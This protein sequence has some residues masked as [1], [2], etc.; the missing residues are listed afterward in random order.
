MVVVK[1]KIRN[2]IVDGAQ[3]VFS[4]HGYRR[5]TMD[6]IAQVL[7]MGKS[8]IYYYFNS[9]EDIFRA[10]VEKEG[11]VLKKEINRV[12]DA[13]SSPLGKLKT[14]IR[15]RLHRLPD[16]KNL[17][18]A[19][20]KEDLPEMDFVINLRKRFNRE[21]KELV[22]RIFQSGNSEGSF[23]VAD[24]VLGAI[25]ISTMMRGLEIPLLY[26]SKDVEER[27]KLMEDLIN[28]ILYGIFRGN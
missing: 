4:R 28:V 19:L 12:L 10:V 13:E 22:T 23:K 7:E 1:E 9:K 11:N 18:E 14:Y 21:E 25:A 17:Y 15:C 20:I 27:R 3:N 24:P 8:S 26:N 16:F 6:E 2:R 5:T